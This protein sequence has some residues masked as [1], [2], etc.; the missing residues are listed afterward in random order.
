MSNSCEVEVNSES[1]LCT[2]RAGQV[3][4][5]HVSTHYNKQY[6]DV[7]PPESQALLRLSSWTSVVFPGKRDAVLPGDSGGRAEA[8]SGL[9]QQSSVLVLS[10][11]VTSLLTLCGPTTDNSPPFCTGGAER[12]KR[13]LRAVG[14]G[15]FCRE[16]VAFWFQRTNGNTF[17]KKRL[18]WLST[19]HCGG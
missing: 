9:W 3:S 12:S 11:S 18:L 7:Q 4:S 16:R 17:E 5:Q 10:H 13:H 2:L 14:A 19:T 1:D 6:F 15:V 8:F